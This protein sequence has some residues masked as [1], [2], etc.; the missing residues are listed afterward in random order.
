MKKNVFGLNRDQA[1]KH[2]NF[3]KKSVSVVSSAASGAALVAVAD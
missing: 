3:K 2:L 1:L